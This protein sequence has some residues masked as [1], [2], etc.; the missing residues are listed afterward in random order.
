MNSRTKNVSINI[1]T[2]LICQ[3]LNLCLNFVSR[4]FFIQ[5]LGVIYLGING[6]FANVLS[7]LSFT[8]LGIGH[9]LVFSMYKPLAE[10]DTEK[11]TSLL[12]IYKKSYRLIALVVMFLGLMYVPFIE[13]TIKEQP[14]IPENLTLIYLLFLFNTV[15][16]FLIVYKKSIITADQKNYLVLITTEI[17]HI[18]QIITQII[19]LVYYHSFIGFL[20]LQIIFTL[21]GNYLAALTANKLYP[22][23][24][25]PP[26][27]LAE[28]E[29]KDIF[30]NV[31]SMAA[32]KFG[33]IVLNSTDNV[34]ISTM[35]GVVQVGL[36]SNYVLLYQAVNS[37][38]GNVVN[39]F[40]ASI[41][42][43]NAVATIDKKYDVFNKVLFITVWLYGFASFALLFL[44]QE[45]IPLWIGDGYLLD[46]PTVVAIMFGFYV[47]GVHTA[48]SHY[49]TTMG[50]FVKGRYAPIASAFLNLILSVLLCKWVG[51]I[52]IFIATPIA[53]IAFIGIIDTYIIY[54]YGFE[55]SP[56]IY[57]WVN[58]KYFMSLT[59]IGVF[60]F[61]VVKQIEM[62]GWSG[63]VIKSIVFTLLFNLIM[64][65]LY[66]R[67][68][69]FKSIVLMIKQLV[70][71]KKEI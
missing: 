52:G 5:Y 18:V 20:V 57:Y 44:S 17:A 42:N 10:K 41:G 29:Q 7:I 21:L 63:F 62:G 55:K 46:F 26:K 33:S 39:S 14:N 4:T 11:L 51:L 34:I 64:L 6:L 25:N 32:Y 58:I 3:L 49:R 67:S 54:K 23:I 40:T 16:S 19:V 59:V 13:Y 8:E 70:N 12:A 68:K 28:Y 27:P 30:R 47:F 60:S 36:V 31:K 48:E 35:V 37:I 61:M 9:A 1:I 65:V 69:H 2:S 71:T 56:Y 53:R 38:L 66:C 22:F 45:L 43:L 24:N 15:S 50:F